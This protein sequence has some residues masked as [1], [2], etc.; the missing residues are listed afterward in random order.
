N[1]FQAVFTGQ[2]DPCTG[3]PVQADD[4]TAPLAFGLP[5]L[6]TGE[7]ILVHD[8]MVVAVTAARRAAAGNAD[9]VVRAPLSQ[10][11]FI[12]EMRCANAIPGASGRITYSPDQT[13]YG[14]PVD[15]PVPIVEIR[16]DGST[17]TVWNN[18]SRQNRTPTPC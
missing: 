6:R 18:A 16:A 4:K 13:Q 1:P 17:T 14:N 10:I 7:G 5:D 12:E 11:G 2:P 9:T 15:K 3:Q 8:A